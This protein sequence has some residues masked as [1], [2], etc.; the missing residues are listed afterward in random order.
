MY[1]SSNLKHFL[2]RL[3]EKFGG[4]YS[5]TPGE[6]DQRFANLEIAVK[7]GIYI[8]LSQQGEFHHALFP[9]LNEEWLPPNEIDVEHERLLAKVRP[10]TREERRQREFY[11]RSLF[12][13][14]TSVNPSHSGRPC[15][16]K[17]NPAEPIY[18]CV[19]C[20]HDA[21]CVLCTYCFNPK[22]HEGHQ[23][24]MDIADRNNE[25][26]CDCGDPEA[27]TRPVVCK[28]ASQPE[29]KEEVSYNHEKFQ[30]GAKQ[31]I[32]DIVDYIIDIF[33]LA[34]WSLPAFHE[35]IVE[36]NFESLKG[37]WQEASDRSSL[38]REKYGND[39]N[40]P[41]AE[42]SHVLCFW[43]DEY[44]NYPEAQDRIR[45]TT[46]CN[47]HT[48]QRIAEQ[49]DSKGMVYLY[50]GDLQSA[51]AKFK[52]ASATGLA[53]SVITARD[54]LRYEIASSLASVLKELVEFPIASI[55]N[56]VRQALC[57]VLL[58]KYDSFT[59]PHCTINDANREKVTGLLD[60]AGKIPPNPVN[61][62][63]SGLELHSLAGN[64]LETLMVGNQD[65][66]PRQS[67]FQLLLFLEIRFW[68][69]LRK[70]IHSIL[71]P[72]M[73]SH[74]EYKSTFCEHSLEIYPHLVYQMAYLDREWRT[75][76]LGDLSV[77]FFTC[78]KTSLTLL[79]SKQF[80]N[81]IVPLIILLEKHAVVSNS[82]VLW[83]QPSNVFSRGASLLDTM[84]KCIN[85]IEHVIEKKSYQEAH[86]EFF[87]AENFMYLV[88]L[89]RLFDGNWQIV[90][91]E[92]DHV[93]QESRVYMAY[94]EFAVTAF[95]LGKHLGRIISAVGHLDREKVRLAISM[96]GNML[97][98]PDIN[99]KQVNDVS[100]PSHVVAKEPTGLMY[101]LQSL[102][103]VMLETAKVTDF[104]ELL[105][106]KIELAPRD[107]SGTLGFSSS[108]VPQKV[109]VLSVTD[110]NLQSAVLCAQIR[111]GFWVRNGVLVSRQEY[112]YNSSLYAQLGPFRNLHML[113]VAAI[114][115]PNKSRFLFTLLDRFA[116]L[117]WFLGDESINETIYD[118]RVYYIIK[119]FLTFAYH[120]F[121]HRS[122]FQ[123]GLSQE[124]KDS[125]A[126]EQLICYRLC[127]GP[128]TYSQL[129]EDLTVE[130][131]EAPRFDNLLS[132]VASYTSP[133][134]LND[135]GMYRLKPQYFS[136]LDPYLLRVGPDDC[137]EVQACLRKELAILKRCKEEDVIIHPHVV[138]LESSDSFNEI[139][140]IF[141]SHVFAKIVYKLLSTFIKEQ[142]EVYLPLILHLLHAI[143]LEDSI[144]NFSYDLSAFIDIPVCNLLLTIASQPSSAS[145]NMIRKA[146]HILDLMILKDSSVIQS[147][148][149][150]FGQE[151][152]ENYKLEKQK[153]GNGGFESREEKTKRVAEKRQLKIKEKFAKQQAEF[154]EKNKH[155]E[156]LQ[157][158]DDS[159]TAETEHEYENTCI[160]CQGPQTSGEMFGIPVLMNVSPAFWKMPRHDKAY[161]SKGLL[162]YKPQL[163]KQTEEPGS[164]ISKR[165]F[166]KKRRRSDPEPL[167]VMDECEDTITGCRHV[168]STCGHGMHLRCFNEYVKDDKS[169]TLGFQC[170]LCRGLNNGLIPSFR[171]PENPKLR[172]DFSK[173]AELHGD[174]FKIVQ[175]ATGVNCH[176][177]MPY[178]FDD[179]LLDVVSSHDKRQD[180]LLEDMTMLLRAN[181][182]LQT[183]HSLD[184]NFF[185][186]LLGISYLLGNTIQLHE[187]SARYETGNED[188]I[189]GLPPVGKNESCLI[190][191][192]I[193]CRILMTV[194]ES[195][196]VEEID[197]E[198]R[199]QHLWYAGFSDCGFF[200][201][202]TLLV[203]QTSESLS[204]IAR[205]MLTKY[206]MVA[207]SSLMWSGVLDPEILT[208]I[209]EVEADTS[210]SS[211][212][213]LIL[214]HVIVHLVELTDDA[215]LVY[216]ADKFD[217]MWN[218]F[219]RAIER[220]AF[221]NRLFSAA[222]RCMLPFYRQL[223]LMTRYFGI[224][225]SPSDSIDGQIENLSRELGIP[226]LEELVPL[227][228][229][230]D[231]FEHH[232]AVTTVGHVIPDSME[233]SILTLDYP[234]VV[235]LID[236][237][238]YLSS[239][240]EIS[241]QETGDDKQLNFNYSFCL[242]CG[243]KIHLRAERG[244]TRRIIQES[245][246]RHFDTYCALNGMT[247]GLFFTPRSN[248]LKVVTGPTFIPPVVD[249]SAANSIL[250]VNLNSPYLNAHG[251]SSGG[252]VGRG[253]S[254][255][256]NQ[257]R[258]R[259]INKLWLN[260]GLTEFVVRNVYD[261][262]QYAD[263]G[264]RVIPMAN[265]NAALADAV[266]GL[267]NGDLPD[268]RLFMRDH[269]EEEE[270]ED[271]YYLSDMEDM[272]EGW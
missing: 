135:A 103:S 179:E 267:F 266:P 72:V 97:S 149:S 44:H 55:Q 10:T 242:L 141:K 8:A 188:L 127:I 245:V 187:V 38:P 166:G 68:K 59:A 236:L 34:P 215:K 216:G 71:T 47:L 197:V 255:Q 106:R 225:F 20:G 137:D 36:L 240:L 122:P 229:N 100:I 101:P 192:L 139:R 39:P 18:R 81:V 109:D 58:E 214:D 76:A 222:R 150:S 121:S 198:K 238:P 172:Q 6:G 32:A 138:K 186:S 168:A 21:T 178:F 45:A 63:R 248:E 180:T 189:D 13:Q 91:K 205:L 96:L 272:Y 234:G 194:L 75:H 25:G 130:V 46:N 17:F 30:R 61:R 90:R 79:T 14:K 136:R 249:I 254:A 84:Q 211:L 107:N 210:S 65:D 258:W 105:E 142:N 253:Q 108:S 41:S 159:A 201:E 161:F 164:G 104:S 70:T 95:R 48:S 77:Q 269:E 66:Y 155:L 12:G 212:K 123:Y 49:I 133:S 213:D 29:I 252:L 16:R 7:R 241:T 170:P 183:I 35:Q 256:L 99:M 73:L 125:T 265:L 233:K 181:T 23:V 117:S 169:F 271:D 193:Q 160:L 191:S 202:L 270:E 220:P 115:E 206:F 5:T 171:R 54:Q 80:K 262:R 143:F 89:L 227:L 74:L 85:D 175:D 154:L 235:K 177:L 98:F 263:N 69:S 145:K 111:T 112:V 126:I 226:T 31:I 182:Y 185:S 250:T 219:L 218:Q 132:K 246:I 176:K 203:F 174:Y 53:S 110:H 33:V 113:Q 116:L 230:E 124:E 86:L 2:A 42:P 184:T 147:L 24:S 165:Y 92:G 128:K 22:N 199:F 62:L 239:F 56:G 204:T 15:A 134:G 37:A 118:D 40:F 200:T 120:L 217:R 148:V 153:K 195:R 93:L 237:P 157:P 83:K 88:C 264:P 156:E 158:E 11:N 114:V 27:W 19:T 257:N 207:V 82:S 50:E 261:R 9:Y 26:I 131:L 209:D 144:Q 232:I 102:L 268:L 223:V 64:K 1:N 224:S 162:K 57:E 151:F 228:L 140:N 243:E 196:L 52:I 173:G 190:N 231:S 67:R 3:P 221:Q 247:Q 119:E 163:D 87:D 129:A 251:E 167:S 94:F 4:A 259:Y 78:P 260:Q 51:C 152:I 146:D 43:N 28:S 208:I 244:F 60:E